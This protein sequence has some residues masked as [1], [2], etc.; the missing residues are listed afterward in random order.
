MKHVR[1]VYIANCQRVDELPADPQFGSGVLETMRLE[2]TG[3]PLW[4]L[5]RARL[6]RC[7]DV[8][9]QALS[10][11]DSAIE[12]LPYLCS[13]WQTPGRVRLRFGVRDGRPQWDLAVVP[14]DPCAQ[15]QTGVTLVPC[16]ATFPR[17]HNSHSGCKTLDRAFYNDAAAAL[18]AP[19]NIHSEDCEGLLQD[20]DGNLIETLRCNLLLWVAGQWI[21]PSLEQYGV[22]GVMR[23]WLQDQL[24]IT[25]G[26]V[27]LDMVQGAEEVALCNSLRG[28]IPVTSLGNSQ[29][30]SPG[31]ETACLQER[32][33]KA[34]W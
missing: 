3:I 13:S 34:L 14:F 29:K 4:P 19:A 30:W 31:R 15:W 28:V 25:E 2:S 5:H 10:D 27:S 23:R 26:V 32:I 22:R 21:T 16:E 33:A 9:S 18:V 6:L 17:N 11:I 12:S 24:P 1:A 8:A 7:N 20:A